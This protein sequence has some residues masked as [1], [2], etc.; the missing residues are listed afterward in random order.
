MNTFIL[1]VFIINGE[2]IIKYTGG[3]I[4]LNKSDFKSNP[5]EEYGKNYKDIAIESVTSDYTNQWY[6]GFLAGF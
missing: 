4:T 3:R 5:S 6:H 1:K 2:K